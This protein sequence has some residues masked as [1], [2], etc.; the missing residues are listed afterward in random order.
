MA[1]GIP[2]LYLEAQ[3]YFQPS[4]KA[5]SDLLRR[6]RGFGGLI[7]TVIISVMSNYPEPPSI[8]GLISTVV[9]RATIRAIIRVLTTLNYTGKW[10]VHLLPIY[11]NRAPRC[12]NKNP[13]QN[14]NPT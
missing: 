10:S 1:L 12:P 2:D 3:G 6:L 5:T 9:T 8:I 13:L 4:Y 11:L 7:S 14:R